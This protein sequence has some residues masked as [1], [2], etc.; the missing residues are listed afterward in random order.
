MVVISSVYRNLTIT[1]LRQNHL[2]NPKTVFLIL[3]MT[4]KRMKTLVLSTQSD[5]DVNE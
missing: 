3:Q 5:Q 2:A 4:I 1:K